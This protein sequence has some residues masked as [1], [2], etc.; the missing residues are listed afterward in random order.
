MPVMI[1]VPMFACLTALTLT[2]ILVFGRP[3]KE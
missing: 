1:T 2:L 3:P